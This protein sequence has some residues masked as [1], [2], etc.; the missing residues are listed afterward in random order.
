MPSV[1]SISSSL[2]ALD[3]F[4]LKTDGTKWSLI[5]RDGKTVWTGGGMNQEESMR[6]LLVVALNQTAKRLESY[7]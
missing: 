3:G 5:N 2:Q 1:Q 4:R 6:T 7:E